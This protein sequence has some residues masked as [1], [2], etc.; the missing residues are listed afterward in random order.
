MPLQDADQYGSFIQTTHDF[1]VDNLQEID[2]KSKE[3]KELLVRLGIY[4]NN[5]ANIL[6]IKDTGRYDIAEFVNGQIFFSDPTLNSGTTQVPQDRQVFRKVINFGALP[7]AGTKST[8]HGITC[9][10]KTSFTRIYGCATDP[11]NKLYIP[12]PYAS[13]TLN[14]NISLSVD[15]TNV[16]VTTGINYSAYTITYLVLEYLQN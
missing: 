9:T 13:T 10:S 8:A 12:L 1:D 11:V 4:V 2:V 14:Q 5:M 6:N 3:F 15:G 16:N 7:N